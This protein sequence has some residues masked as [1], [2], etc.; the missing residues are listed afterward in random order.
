M[1]L[2]DIVNV[3]IS[4]QTTAVSQR[5]FGT[6]LVVAYHDKFPERARIYKSLEAMA[7]EKLPDDSPMWPSSDPTYRAVQAIFSQ[8]PKVDQVV[9]GRATRASTMKHILAPVEPPRVGTKYTVT[10]NGHEFQYE[11][12]EADETVA[13]ITAGLTEKINATANNG[14]KYAPVTAA[15]ADGELGVEADVAGEVY[16]LE[17]DRSL[18]KQK[19]TTGKPEPDEPGIEPDGIEADIA[20][21]QE[22]NDDWYSIHLTSVGATEILAAAAYI[23]TQ[24]KLLL[25]ASADDDILGSQVEDDIGSLLQSPGYARTALLYHPKPHSYPAAAWAGVMLPKDPGSATWKFKSISG[26]S[27]IHLTGA[28][29]A[30]LESKNVNYYNVVAGVPISQQGY[31]SS[32]EFIDITRFVDFLRARLQESIFSRLANLDK[33]PY[34]DNGVGVI[35]NEVR[36]VLQLGI[37][38][39]GLAADPQPVVLVPKVA[40]VPFNDRANRFLP[41]VTFNATLAGAIHALEVTGVVSV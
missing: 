4:T 27:S 17:V 23:E 12:Q 31:T 28:E 18:I 10:I 33:V 32:G 6:P 37:N 36:G 14:E 9:V 1:S 19:N 22:Q 15:V 21:I 3:S 8:N 40:D 2:D 25:V 38:A 29:I 41:D 5:G 26:I 35:E 20:E 13:E 34:T 7:E 11:T 30:A 16:T 39:G 24:Y